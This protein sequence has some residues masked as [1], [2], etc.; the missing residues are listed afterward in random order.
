MN[1]FHYILFALLL[2]AAIKGGWGVIA[3]YLVGCFAS[4]LAAAILD[5]RW[6]GND[7]YVL[8]GLAI[9]SLWACWQACLMPGRIERIKNR[10]VSTT[11]PHN[12][13]TTPK[14]TQ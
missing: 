13:D 6:G 4:F 8:L 3:F 12:I 7:W 11:L 5:Y 10:I 1:P 2:Y 14:D 9:L